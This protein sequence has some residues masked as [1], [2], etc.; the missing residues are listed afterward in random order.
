VTARRTATRT[1]LGLGVGVLSAYATSVAFDLPRRDAAVLILYAGLGAGVTALA[2]LVVLRGTRRRSTATQV[3]VA[4]LTAVAASAVG[5]LVAANRMFISTHDLRALLVVV[6]VGGSVGV[7]VAL[8]VGDAVGAGTRKLGELARA[9]G[10]GASAPAPPEDL[11]RELVGLARE[12]RRMDEMLGESRDRERA[13]ETSR[14]ELV[15]WVSHDLRT[16]LAGIRAMA[17]A[18]E[19]GVVVDAETVNRYHQ[20][21]RI[22]ADR[23]TGMVD[24]LFELSRIH[25]GALRLQLERVPL[26]DLVSDALAAADPL[27][28]AKG[29]R[30][31]GA[32]AGAPAV[33]VSVDE[34]SRV[35]RNLL[36][37]AIRHT[38]SDGTVEV[39]SGADA[40]YAYV[41]VHDACGGIP[42]QDIDRVF[43]VAFR[44]EAARTP[45]HG[46]GAGLGLAIARGIVEAHSGD[47][48]VE[49]AGAGCRF[50]VRL[51]L[52]A[53]A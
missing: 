34:V 28:S 26:G 15:A 22:E 33:A 21:L 13:V 27:A 4:V 8:A 18:L 24:D 46:G 39:E 40:T 25:A 9:I 23:L 3:T 48:T 11:S 19:D 35:L 5:V 50:L 49:N 20:R 41:A 29:V 42:E 14:R 36:H 44:G 51:P 7:A 10:S 43:D 53:T 38:P 45:A 2:G 32:V 12:L 16:P 47:I 52:S 6:V 30:L 37:N 31:R 17:E 1:A